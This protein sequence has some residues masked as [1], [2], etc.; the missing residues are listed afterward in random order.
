MLLKE[1]QLCA[2]CYLCCRVPAAL[3]YLW[4]P[5]WAALLTHI[6]LVSCS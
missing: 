5:F 2:C 6:V 1:Q 3:S 4:E